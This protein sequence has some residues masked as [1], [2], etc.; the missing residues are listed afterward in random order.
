MCFGNQPPVTIFPLLCGC[1]SFLACLLFPPSGPGKTLTVFIFIYAH[2]HS[3]RVAG[4]L[5]CQLSHPP[6]RAWIGGPVAE[7]E[8]SVA[9][10]HRKLLSLPSSQKHKST[11]SQKSVCL[12]LLVL[13][14]MGR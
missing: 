14:L 11:E 4:I 9:L 5:K 3:C 12:D 10:R 8:T 1:W 13:G 7:E 2:T 6:F